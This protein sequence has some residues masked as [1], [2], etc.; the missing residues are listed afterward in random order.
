M[1]TPESQISLEMTP[2]FGEEENIS[3]ADE[4]FNKFWDGIKSQKDVSKPIAH[5]LF[6]LIYNSKIL[7]PQSTTT[8]LALTNNKSKLKITSNK[9]V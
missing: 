3:E 7:V 8:N 5:K 1:S 4:L 2:Q 6:A 9:G